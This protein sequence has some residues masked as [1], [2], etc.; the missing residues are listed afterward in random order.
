MIGFNLCFLQKLLFLLIRR[1][2]DI[3]SKFLVIPL[4]QTRDFVLESNT[5]SKEKSSFYL[6]VHSFL[7]SIP[8]RSAVA[9]PCSCHFSTLVCMSWVRFFDP[10]DTLCAW[11]CS[12]E[13]MVGVTDS[14]YQL[15][16]SSVRLILIWSTDSS[17]RR[18]SARFLY[19]SLWT[20]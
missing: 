13:I 6:T 7:H 18:V 17:N 14:S 5:C 3:L 8:I 20:V 12:S 19:L 4:F 9:H 2:G 10:S 16:L 11:T 15:P 1:I